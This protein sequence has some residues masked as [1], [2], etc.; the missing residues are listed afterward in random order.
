MKYTYQQRKNLNPAI[1]RY[2][3]RKEK[4]L[5]KK[6]RMIWEFTNPKGEKYLFANFCK[7]WEKTIVTVGY[8]SPNIHQFITPR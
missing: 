7:N 1:K 4:Y 3:K 6:C 8:F 2:I 5:D